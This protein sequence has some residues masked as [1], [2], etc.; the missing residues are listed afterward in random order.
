MTEITLPQILDERE[1]RVAIQKDLLKKYSCPL[2]S[3]T[4]NIAGP[5]KISPI[6][7]RAFNWGLAALERDLGAYEILSRRVDYLVTGC[8]AI[9][10]VKT[11]P[12][13]IKDLCLAIEDSTPL[14]RLF[15]MDVI[16]TDGSKLERQS[17]RGCIVC[18]AGCGALC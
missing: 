12:Q 15:D 17:L 11:D 4:M 7:T 10:A 9:I 6:I 13:T 8:R 3:F 14:G 5:I 2:I 1:E 18:G 16:N